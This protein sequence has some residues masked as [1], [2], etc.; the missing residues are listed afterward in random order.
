[1]MFLA[2]TLGGFGLSV[3]FLG[4]LIY[5]AILEPFGVPYFASIKFS[6]DQQDSFVRLP[7][8][9]ME[10]RPEGLPYIDEKRKKTF[11]PPNGKDN[12]EK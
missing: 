6:R 5:L 8:W 12:I 7:L 1:M 4:V 10:D 2:S 3:G 9:I 11:I